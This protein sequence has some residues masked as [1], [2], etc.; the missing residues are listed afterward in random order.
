MSSLDEINHMT[1]HGIKEANRWASSNEPIAELALT[2]PFEPFDQLNWTA[3]DNVT[4][5][6]FDLMVCWN[7][8]HSSQLWSIIVH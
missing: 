8:W 6:G 5:C 3:E 7:N 4:E 2:R 1:L